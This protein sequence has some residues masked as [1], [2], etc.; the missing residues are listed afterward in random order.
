MHKL[1]Q[2]TINTKALFAALGGAVA[3]F[4]RK[5]RS[6]LGT[7]ANLLSI[8][9]F[10][11][12]LIAL[13]AL[14]WLYLRPIQTANIKVPVA[15]DQASY[16]P[17]EDISGIFFGDT[18]YTGE[19]RVLREVFCKD[20]KG[21]IKPPAESADGNFFS[22]QGRRRH[23]EGQSVIVGNLPS[24]VPVGSNCVLQFTNVYNVQTPF[25]IRHLEYQYYTQNFAIVTKER[26]MQLECEASGRKDCNY[27]I[28]VPKGVEQS[29]N[30][31]PVQQ[32]S[33]E[34]VNT[35][36]PTT[37]NTFNDN[38]STTNNT[39]NNPPSEPVQPPQEHCTV[40]LLGIKAF[41]STE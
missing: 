23:L 2:L 36:A 40:D 28:D 26:R 9:A 6:L 5:N 11:I 37:N 41:C 32:S 38:R 16:Y 4:Y 25:G 22:T 17:G 39:T 29:S 14:V 31:L 7:V 30:D 10:I 20:Y 35:S 1:K 19:V 15:T 24:D 8:A 3:D 27:I 18:Y 33:P 13:A 21:V 34:T 12:G